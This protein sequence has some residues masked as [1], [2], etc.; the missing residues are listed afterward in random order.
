MERN[1][2]STCVL[3]AMGMQA[4]YAANDAH[5]DFASLESLYHNDNIPSYSK[6]EKKP[7]DK[8]IIGA[9]GNFSDLLI[10][11]LQI[12]KSL[13]NQPIYAY[14]DIPILVDEI[15]VDG[16]LVEDGIAQSKLNK[17]ELNKT[18][19][20]Q[21]NQKNAELITKNDTNQQ[22]SKK[23]A[24]N[25]TEQIEQP[26]QDLSEEMVFAQID[27]ND[28][29]YKRILA[30]LNN[31][32]ALIVENKSAPTLSEKLDKSAD[33]IV[34]D[35]TSQATVA[36]KP[37]TKPAIE[38]PKPINSEATNLTVKPKAI[39]PSLPER[40]K[41][42]E[43]A[44]KATKQN[45][46]IDTNTKTK[47]DT[48]QAKTDSTKQAKTQAKTNKPSKAKTPSMVVKKPK[49][50]SDILKK[51]AGDAGEEK[52]L[53]EVFTASDKR[54]SLLKQGNWGMNYDANYSYYR[55]SK[56]DAATA[57][58]SSQ[59]L[60]FRVEENA[61]HT[62]TNTLGVQFGVLDNLT[63]TADLPIVAKTDLSKDAQTVALGDVGIGIRWE[64]FPLKKGRLPLTFN[65]SLSLPTG[66]SP[67]DVDSNKG[68]STGRGY[69]GFSGGVSTRKY[70]DPVV[71]FASM[72][73]NYGLEKKGL[74]YQSSSNRI[75]NAVKPN[76]GVGM[77]LGF[78]YSLNYDVSLTMSYQQAFSMGSEFTVRQRN[79]KK[80]GNPLEEFT[81]SS[82]DQASATLNMAL[83]VRTSPKTIVNT[84]LGIGLTED[85][86]DVSF[87]VSFPLDFVGLGKRK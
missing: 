28:P 66:N 47:A 4:A 18:E 63:L 82:A 71:L 69:Y 15:F 7:V 19:P 10:Q 8:A 57:E 33:K 51:K 67:Y 43:L 54:Y 14:Q 36:V 39:K 79:T 46:K 84:S 78:A 72:S 58:G 34:S 27:T 17:T 25:L 40:P 61:Q 80:A 21:T 3:F 77:A 42:N 56:I 31:A 75:I 65:S 62:L 45:I 52:N 6:V 74:N 48:K 24:K 16:L 2:L 9:D 76:I 85:A 83:G 32:N 59:I 1:V 73:G 37:S 30:Q 38:K 55:D 53:K 49:K 81:V 50:A 23:P 70:I 64:P 29:D 68:L 20:N 60:R 35:A 41:A 87:G 11:D 44:A 86:P 13:I 22:L 12:K 5:A 26:N